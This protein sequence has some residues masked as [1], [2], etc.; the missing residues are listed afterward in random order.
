M[1]ASHE[2]RLIAE[3]LKS[4]GVFPIDT[5]DA[6]K[7]ASNYIMSVHHTA[8]IQPKHHREDHFIPKPQP[9]GKGNYTQILK[10]IGIKQRLS[11]DKRARYPRRRLASCF[12]MYTIRYS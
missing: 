11:D 1:K 7:L 4:V 6:K 10:Y 5:R 12:T 2:D 8:S 9:L 3:C